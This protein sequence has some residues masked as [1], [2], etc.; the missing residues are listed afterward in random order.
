MDYLK[1]YRDLIVKRL[2]EPSQEKYTQVHHIIPRS[3]DPSKTKDKKNL[4]KLSAREHFIAHALL[5]RITQ[6]SNNK[7][8]YYKMLYAFKT[9]SQFKNGQRD[10]INSH[11][12][13]QLKHR[14][15]DI[16]GRI[17]IHNKNTDENK[18]ILIE[19]YE[20]L[21]HQIWLKGRSQYYLTKKH[22]R[23]NPSKG[24]ICIYNEELKKNKFIYE[25]QPIPEGW[26]VGRVKSNDYLN[27]TTF[28]NGA[29]G[30]MWICNDTTQQYKMINKDEQIPEGW[31]KGRLK[32]FNYKIK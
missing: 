18:V 14:L 23:Y 16:K 6:K 32:G 8:N 4:V 9:M 7:E 17:W 1:I 22:K 15:L 12:F 29:K 30:K 28:I 24:K 19:Q 21:D 10:F 3:I 11:L 2:K 26:R 13:Q 20:N 31:R 5:V 27:N 25:N